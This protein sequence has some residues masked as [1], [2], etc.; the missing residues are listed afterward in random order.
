MT[1]IYSRDTER[2]VLG[3]MISN[4]NA[5]RIGIEKLSDNCF[6][7]VQNKNV[8]ISIREIY[9]QG[10][11]PDILNITEL[12]LTRQ[13]S[14]AS[15]VSDL[16][17]NASIPSIFNQHIEEIVEFWK[18]REFLQTMN[19]ALE[20][21][22]DPLVKLEDLIHEVQD[23]TLPLL[24]TNSKDKIKTMDVIAME[25]LKYIEQVSKTGG[26]TGIPCGFL[27]IDERH[28]GFQREELYIIAARPSMGKSQLSFQF[29]INMAKRDY[30][31]LFF[32]LEMSARQIYSRMLSNESMIHHKKIKN[33]RMNE[34]EMAEVLNASIGL[35]KLPIKIDD[36]ATSYIEHIENECRMAKRLDVVIIDHLQLVE[37]KNKSKMDNRNVELDII[38]KKMKTLA[39]NLHV[40]VLCM[41]QLSREN[42]K[43]SDH[44]PI[45]SDLRESGAIEQNAD[46]VM[47][48]YRDEYYHEESSEKGIAEIITSKFRDGQVGTD[49][50]VF[51][52]DVVKFDNI[53]MHGGRNG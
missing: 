35:S 50:M 5:A 10:K 52:A 24:E 1:P 39:K 29:G 18:K 4:N 38:T 48:I 11:T 45:L 33:A 19:D 32:A 13:E 17:S 42:A 36:S 46:V 3:A 40:P 27:D 23:K 9:A 49:K 22:A 26:Y 8:F 37:L 6:F 34:M 28:G 51:M 47:F 21:L 15:Y 20:Q 31:V 41:S 25:T 53:Y 2:A 14:T 44:R 7:D 43:R 12:L 16:T 30:N